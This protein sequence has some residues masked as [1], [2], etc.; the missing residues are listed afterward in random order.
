M[1]AAR[2]TDDPFDV[3]GMADDPDVDLGEDLPTTEVIYRSADETAE[4]EVA[5]ANPAV[6]DE[7]E[8]GTR[9][10][11]EL[12]RAQQALLAEIRN[13]PYKVLSTPF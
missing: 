9:D 2:N 7:P 8:P 4:P 12:W 6:Q 3:P 10:E 13:L 5:A 11:R 1:S